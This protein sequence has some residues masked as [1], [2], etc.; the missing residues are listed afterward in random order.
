MLSIALGLARRTEVGCLCSL[1]LRS[2]VRLSSRF[3]DTVVIAAQQMLWN[4]SIPFDC[5]YVSIL[6]VGDHSD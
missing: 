4:P 5:W 6:L 3:I 1:S 2:L